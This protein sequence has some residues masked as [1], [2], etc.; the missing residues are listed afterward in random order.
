MPLVRNAVYRF[1]MVFFE[2][3]KRRSA[4]GRILRTNGEVKILGHITDFIPH[5]TDCLLLFVFGLNTLFGVNRLEIRQVF[6]VVFVGVFGL[7]E[8]FQFLFV[9]KLY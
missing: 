3:C 1:F 2:L 8:F 4:A 6:L 5:F 7:V 9:L